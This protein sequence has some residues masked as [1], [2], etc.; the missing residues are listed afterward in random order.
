[1][2]NIRFA[3]WIITRKLSSSHSRLLRNS[4]STS[5]NKE[6]FLKL[7][8]ERIVKIV[9]TKPEMLQKEYWPKKGGLPQKM[10]RFAVSKKKH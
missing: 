6:K 1:M 10:K 9:K 7:F 8:N 2:L 5:G 3:S 4:Y